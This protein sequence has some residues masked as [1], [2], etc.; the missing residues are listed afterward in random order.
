SLLTLVVMVSTSLVML[1]TPAG[2]PPEG[3]SV[4][5][6]PVPP[7][8]TTETA[9]LGVPLTTSVPPLSVTGPAPSVPGLLATSVL[10]L[11]IVVPPVK[12]LAPFSVRAPAPAWTSLPPAGVP[13]ARVPA[14]LAAAALLTVRVLL[15]RLILPPVPVRAE[16][17]RFTPVP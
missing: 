13:S 9:P 12:V 6:V 14:K 3:L 5:P 1:G 11:W 4:Q 16:V 2:F 17:V 15:F 8:P 10:E 7:K